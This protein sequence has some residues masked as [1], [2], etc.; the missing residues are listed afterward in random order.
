MF[1]LQQHVDTVRII[2]CKVDENTFI[3]QRIKSMDRLVNKPF[4]YETEAIEGLTIQH[5]HLAAIKPLS[6]SDRLSLP[7]D[8]Q[9]F[10]TLVYAFDEAHQTEGSRMNQPGLRDDNNPLVMDVDDTTA[11]KESERLLME[12]VRDL[13]SA[14]YYADPSGKLVSDKIHMLSKAV[15]NLDYTTLS[16]FTAKYITPEN[17][18][19]TV[20]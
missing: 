5:L 2:G 11:L 12:I 14:Q 8:V 20:K 1:L 18:W 19:S 16:T 9:S 3:V 17:N 15:S 7:R 6:T 4:G 13:E 10:K